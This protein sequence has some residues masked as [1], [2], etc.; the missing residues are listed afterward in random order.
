[1]ASKGV[2]KLTN[3]YDYEQYN[4]VVYNNMK[5]DAVNFS[6]RLKD[7]KMRTIK[8]TKLGLNG[9]HIKSFVKNDRVTIVPHKKHCNI[10]NEN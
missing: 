8:Q 4:R 3:E 10:N 5:Y 7:G 1:M 6:I 9:T 2:S